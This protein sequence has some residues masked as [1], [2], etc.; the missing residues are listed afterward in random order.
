M[1]SWY[2]TIGDPAMT[3][4]V[5]VG[6]QPQPDNA[7]VFASVRGILQESLSKRNAGGSSDT[8]VTLRTCWESDSA[9]LRD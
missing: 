9:C 4:P 6:A 1:C 8:L 7:S 2:R 5:R 3:G